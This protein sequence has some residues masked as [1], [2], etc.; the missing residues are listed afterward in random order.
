MKD[1]SLVFVSLCRSFYLGGIYVK[2]LEEEMGW[3][4]KGRGY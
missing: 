3:E 2:L 4:G 1:G